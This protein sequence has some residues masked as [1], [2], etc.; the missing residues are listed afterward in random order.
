LWT[1]WIRLR[2][3]TEDEWFKIEQ[4]KMGLDMHFR[5]EASLKDPT[6]FQALLQVC[7]DYDRRVKMMSSM[8]FPQMT[9]LG[10]NLVPRANFQASSSIVHGGQVFPNVY[11]ITTINPTSV[12]QEVEQVKNEED[13]MT[14]VNR[15][16]D[17]VMTHLRQSQ[18]I[19][20]PIHDGGG[21][22]GHQSIICY[23]CQE[24]GH[25]STRCPHQQQRGMG[26]DMYQVQMNGQQPINNGV[27]GGVTLPMAQVPTIPHNVNVLNFIDDSDNSCEVALVKRR[28]S[29]LKE[30]EVE[31]ES[32]ALRQKK[33]SKEKEK[34]EKLRRR[35]SKRKIKMEDIL[36]GE[37]VEAFNL[38][39]ELISSGTRI[40]WPQ[41]LQLS[42][43][44]RKEWGHLASICQ[45]RKTV[46]YVGIVRVEDRKDIRPT[47]PV[48]IK[49]FHIK[50]ALVDSGARVSLISKLVVN[51]VGIP[52]SRSSL[53]RVVAT[54]GGMVHCIGIVKDVGIKCFRIRGEACN[55]YRINLKESIR[56]S[57]KLQ[58]LGV[59]GQLLQEVKAWLQEGFNYNMED[60]KSVPPMA[61]VPMKNEIDFKPVSN[62][63]K[64]DEFSLP[65]QDEIIDEM[66]IYTK[67]GNVDNV[68]CQEG[69][70]VDD[71]KIEGI[72]KMTIPRRLEAL[73]VFVQKV[74]SL[75]RFIHMLTC[76]LLSRVMYPM[77]LLV[78]GELTKT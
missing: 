52:I 37:G 62:S 69:I 76:L 13:T 8:G 29:L 21:S 28:R 23:S 6:T 30:K 78:F 33:K 11:T 50:D 7:Q 70:H 56:I 41:L 53:A 60:L 24:E 55:K 67:Q 57:P 17:E 12:S 35:C 39:H 75:E 3:G 32:S 73:K 2:G 20:N 27:E 9:T 42:P 64:R 36:M 72:Q 1:T 45:S 74:Q 66:V 68:L 51:K 19:H 59:E 48:S 10:A 38:K 46:H 63:I 44:L 25:I 14:L 54:I 16:V 34:K 15:R 47:I 22:R 71:S 77:A 65:F 18:A 49:G 58:P 40:T 26:R 61:L 4:F 43:T 5:L 31:G